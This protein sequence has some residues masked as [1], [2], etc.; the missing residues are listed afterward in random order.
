M[1]ALTFRE[2]Y[3]GEGQNGTLVAGSGQNGTLV[4]SEL[5][6]EGTFLVDACGRHLN[7]PLQSGCTLSGLQAAMQDML[8]MKGQ[9]F[10]FSDTTGATLRSNNDIFEAVQQGRLPILATLSDASIHAIENRREELA[11]MQWKLVRDK[12]HG[13]ESETAMLGRNITELRDHFRAHVEETAEKMRMMQADISRSIE[14][15]FTMAQSDTGKVSENVTSLAHLLAVEKENRLSSQNHVQH[16]IQEVHELLGNEQQIREK[17]FERN[18]ITLREGKVALEAQ[19]DLHNRLEQQTHFER[20]TMKNELQNVAKQ[21]NALDN[22][23][24]KSFR[25]TMDAVAAKVLQN[26]NEL[27]RLATLDEKL[28]NQISLFSEME[29]RYDILDGRLTE[30]SKQQTDRFDRIVERQEKLGSLMDENLSHSRVNTCDVNSTADRVR[31][32]E[33]IMVRNQDEMFKFIQ[34][35]GIS[36]RHEIHRSK[37]QSAQDHAKNLCELQSKIVDRL[38]VESA[39]REERNRQLQENISNVATR[40]GVED[41]PPASTAT[42]S[43]NVSV[44]ASAPAVRVAPPVPTTGPTIASLPQGVSF[45]PAHSPEITHSPS[46]SPRAIKIPQFQQVQQVPTVQHVPAVQQVPMVQQ[47]P[48]SGSPMHSMSPTGAA[49]I[50]VSPQG[51]PL[52]RSRTASFQSVHSAAPGP[53]SGSI[54]LPCFASAPPGSPAMN[55]S[56]RRSGAVS[57][58]P[59]RPV[60][61]VNVQVPVPVQHV[62]QVQQVNYEAPTFVFQ[63]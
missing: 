41:I 50:P 10:E 36:V 40:S 3:G 28:S 31:A 14:E 49:P 63:P 5:A 52:L 47:V 48:G 43:T 9:S 7:V 53:G 6:T 46:S 56:P 55:I 33:E 17:Q 24:I 34:Q 45:S 22:D 18:L 38:E 27:A 37:Q 4:M 12:M 54:N 57:P 42:R 15:K 59:M 8:Q 51:P 23:Q 13:M 20:D 60:Q 25:Q 35:E 11:Q 1:A 2:L 62:Q 44:S 16:Q 26:S 19:K 32:L 30:T 39:N 21:F 61:Q 29:G 58:P